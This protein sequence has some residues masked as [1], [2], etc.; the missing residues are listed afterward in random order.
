MQTQPNH[1]HQ[2]KRNDPLLQIIRTQWQNA[3]NTITNVLAQISI[4][5]ENRS[6]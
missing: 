5:A 6:Q 2:N 4:P 3:L 1:P